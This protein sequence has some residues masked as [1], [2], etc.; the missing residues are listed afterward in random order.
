MPS[1]CTMSWGAL[2]GLLT[3]RGLLCTSTDSLVLEGGAPSHVV[4]RD[5]KWPLLST[6][7]TEVRSSHPEVDPMIKDRRG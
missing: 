1:A 6:T 5:E 3:P 2:L 7:H 4:P